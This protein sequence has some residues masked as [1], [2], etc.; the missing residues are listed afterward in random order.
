MDISIQLNI[1]S[2]FECSIWGREVVVV[3]MVGVVGVV[4]EGGVLK[5]NWFIIDFRI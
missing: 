1:F 3:G 2:M 4:V 5:Y